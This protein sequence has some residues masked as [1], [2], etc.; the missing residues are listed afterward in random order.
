MPTESP[1]R[2]ACSASSRTLACSERRLSIPVSP[3]MTES[4]RCSRSELISA[5]ESRTTE[6]ISTIDP[7]LRR[8][9]RRLEAWQR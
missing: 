6:L 3:S 8:S 7:R 2:L 1:D 9:M 4:E 5:V